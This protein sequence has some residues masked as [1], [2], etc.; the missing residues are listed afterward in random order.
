M[1]TVQF[2]IKTNRIEHYIADGFF[3]W[4]MSVHFLKAE[5]YAN[6][7]AI[8][9]NNDKTTV[10]WSLQNDDT[11]S[12]PY[13]TQIATIAQN[14]SYWTGIPDP[15]A[16]NNCSP[17]KIIGRYVRLLFR[18]MV[19]VIYAIMSVYTKRVLLYLQGSPWDLVPMH[20]CS[21]KAMRGSTILF[22][23]LKEPTN[24]MGLSLWVCSLEFC[25][26]SWFLYA[27]RWR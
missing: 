17:T 14:A 12:M 13:Y 2:W 25:N 15:R 9:T 7:S 8:S 6:N 16:H 10:Q 20:A 26:G 27:A 22:Q 21:G 19:N 23:E 3:L 11:F 24:L 5:T 1:L 4:K 18:G